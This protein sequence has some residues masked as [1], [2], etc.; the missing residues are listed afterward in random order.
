MREKGRR[1]RAEEKWKVEGRS[2]GQRGEEKKNEERGRE[3]KE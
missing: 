2:E 3:E 1:K